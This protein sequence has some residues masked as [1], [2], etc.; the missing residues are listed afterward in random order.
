[1]NKQQESFLRPLLDMMNKRMDVIG[2]KIDANTL[3]TEKTLTQA[4]YTNGR[5]SKLEQKV[6]DMQNSSAAKKVSLSPNVI[7]LIALGSVILLV[8]IAVLLKI[9]IGGLL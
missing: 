8:I 4:Q 7:Y 1:M 6:A 5:V 2:N 9:P 3:T